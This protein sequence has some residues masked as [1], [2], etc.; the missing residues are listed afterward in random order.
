MEFGNTEFGLINAQIVLNVRDFYTDKPIRVLKALSDSLLRVDTIIGFSRFDI[1]DRPSIESQRERYYITVGE[2]G[3]TKSPSK[4]IFIVHGRS[5]DM[6]EAVARVLEKLGLEPIIL[7][8][9]P[10]KG[11]TLIEKFTDYSDV[12]FA[13]VLLSADDMGYQEGH[14]PEEAKPRAR[15]NVIFELGFFIGKLGRERVVP[16]YRKLKAFE[17]PSDYD[18]VVYTPYDLLGA[19][20]TELVRELRA[21]GYE[22][23]ANKLI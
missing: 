19:W 4:R 15:Q 1:S 3:E 16:L 11:R 20:K 10:N 7:H 22:V 5:K 23:D 2:T 8:E 21:C 13:V 9:K 14:S 12:G 6:K 18:G 17:L